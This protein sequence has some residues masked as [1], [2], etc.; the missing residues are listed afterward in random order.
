M[1]FHEVE[2]GAFSFGLK[3]LVDVI[4]FSSNGATGQFTLSS[5]I[6]EK[7]GK[8]LAA[9][10]MIVSG[11]HSC[12]IAILPKAV[13]VNGCYSIH[14]RE[15]KFSISLARIGLIK[16]KRSAVRVPHEITEDGLIIDIRPLRNAPLKVAA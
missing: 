16:G 2:K 7:L 5:D 4:S 12:F 6:F 9:K 15:R 14:K 10:V 3:K 11:E 1:A 8:P 13:A